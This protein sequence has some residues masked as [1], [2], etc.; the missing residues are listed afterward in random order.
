MNK[1]E[2]V[3]LTQ[4]AKKDV[5]MNAMHKAQSQMNPGFDHGDLQTAEKELFGDPDEEWTTLQQAKDI[6]ADEEAKLGV[7]LNKISK[8]CKDDK[9]VPD[10]VGAQV[11]SWLAEL[12]EK[13]TLEPDEN[14]KALN[15]LMAEQAAAAEQA[16]K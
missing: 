9:S 7:F 1:T 15:K 16:K 11:N 3:Q 4:N 2:S 8:A 10:D 6:S 12:N 13:G 5:K 14:A